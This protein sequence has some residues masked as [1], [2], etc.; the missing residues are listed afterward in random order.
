MFSNDYWNTRHIVCL[1]INNLLI[2]KNLNNLIVLYIIFQYY[3][4]LYYI[5]KNIL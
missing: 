2:K 1:D 3:I 5:I 4:V